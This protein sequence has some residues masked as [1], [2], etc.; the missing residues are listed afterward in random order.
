ME[1][2]KYNLKDKKFTQTMK[3]G[4]LELD[5]DEEQEDNRKRL[6]HY[7]TFKKKQEDQINNG[8]FQIN[9]IGGSKD[10]T[11]ESKQNHSPLNKYVNKSSI[12]VKGEDLTGENFDE[13]FLLTDTIM[14]ARRKRKR[15]SSAI[16]ET[17]KIGTDSFRTLK[18]HQFSDDYTIENCIGQGGYGKVYKVKHN[19]MGHTRAMKS[20]SDAFLK[21]LT[22]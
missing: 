20:K 8:S 10:E 22:I 17:V 15:Y 18:V 3:I 12:G 4:D 19:S 7:K 9:I 11:I 6:T 1:D 16:L 2:R 21:I 5:L 14:P 13:E